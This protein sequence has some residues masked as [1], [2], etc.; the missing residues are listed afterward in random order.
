MP[1]EACVRQESAFI[2]SAPDNFRLLDALPRPMGFRDYTTSGDRALEY[3]KR[4]AESGYAPGKDLLAAF[5][6]EG[7]ADLDDVILAGCNH[8]LELAR[9]QRADHSRGYIPAVEGLGEYYDFGI[10]VAV[11]HA[12]AVALYRRAVEAGYP[13][14]QYRLGDAY[15]YERSRSYPQ[16]YKQA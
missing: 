7:K 4:A 15:Q 12:Q 2:V 9:E 10:G 1:C 13:Y 16:D 14:A 3:A 5:Y 11:D 8:S 6:F